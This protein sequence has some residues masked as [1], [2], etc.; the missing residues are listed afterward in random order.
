MFDQTRQEI[1]VHCFRGALAGCAAFGLTACAMDSAQV[2]SAGGPDIASAQAESYNGPKARIA[3]LDFQDKMSSS[4]QYNAAYGRGMSDMLNT[5]LFQTNRYIVLER[6]K[7]QEVIGEQNLGA[8]GRVKKGTAAAIGEIEGAELLITA[9]ITGF[10]PGVAS[11]EGNLRGMLGDAGGMLGS[12]LPEGFSYKKAHVAMDLRVVDSRTA[13]VV[14]ATSVEGSASGFSTAGSMAGSVLTGSLSSFS[15]TPMETAIREMIRKA[16]AFIVAQTPQTYYHF[17]ASGAQGKA[18]ASAKPSRRADRT[19]ATEVSKQSPSR[20]EGSIMAAAEEA[21][22]KEPEAAETNL[23]RAE[24]PVQGKMAPPEDEMGTPKALKTLQSIRSNFD[25][26]IVAHLN[27]VTR[28]GA[29]LSVV[30]SLSFEGDK[31][32]STWVKVSGDA[33]ETNVM[34]YETGKTYPILKLDGFYNGRIEQ[35][36]VKTLRA[37]FQAPKDA[38]TVGITLSGIG[39]FDD[40]RLGK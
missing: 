14:A 13:R 21:L 2:T 27:E 8:S 34:D 12:L 15:K 28:R 20:P 18:V 33:A 24:E 1:M 22:E 10:D 7:L 39:T 31:K 17:S 36:R 19:E 11:K 26:D 16:V 6:D 37:T 38:K 9:A 23:V 30:V 4:G 32:E 35:G 3:V 25:K 40:V 29:V 5:A